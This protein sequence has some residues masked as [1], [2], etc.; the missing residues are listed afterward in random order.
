MTKSQNILLTPEQ[1]GRADALA[2]ENGV[3]SLTLMENAGRAVFDA[4]VTR[5]EPCKVLVLCGPGNNGG[6]GYVVARL[7]ADSGWPVRLAH[8]GDPSNLKGDAAVMAAKWDGAVSTA[9]PFVIAGAE[10]IVD[11]LLGAGLDRDVTGPLAG[12]VDAING[13]DVPVVAIDVPSGIDGADGAVRGAAVEAVCTA[14]FFRKK[15]GH[16]LLPGKVNCGDVVVSDIGIPESVLDEI[17]ATAFE[18]NSG[19][20]Q[21]PIIG[22]EF[23]K[24]S[25]GHCVVVSGNEL[26]TGAA[27]LAAMGALRAGA[28]L[29][30]LAG[31]KDALLVHA[32][33]VTSIM[34]AEADDAGRLA[35]L[36]QDRRKNAV[37]IGPGA[38][39]GPHTHQSVSAVLASGAAV[40]LDA[41]ALTSFVGDEGALFAAIKDKP[42]RSVVMTPHE[43][44]FGRLFPRIKGDKLKRARESAALSGAVI[45]LK[46]ADSVIAAPDGWAAVNVGAPAW[47][48]TA[49][50]GDVLAG[51]V[52]GLLAQGMMGRDAAAA[53]VYLH[54]LAAQLFGGPG[55]IAEDLPELVPDALQMLVKNDAD[56]AS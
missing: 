4:I 19:L 35:T 36:L 9:E 42:A 39:V 53:G 51:I 48:S 2:V 44:E 11:G 52:G 38:G 8:F 46:G 22:A 23:H 14:T 40:V 1:M 49:G 26:H 27:R 29:V 18:N 34:L 55:L 24:Y 15:P 6:D 56:D 37:V 10:L 20:W 30:S 32:A 3:P 13:A 5:F 17:N 7:L 16:V 45:V 12:L 50:S 33:Q 31:T 25:R 54:G 47:L 21:L 28:G 43:G 41:D